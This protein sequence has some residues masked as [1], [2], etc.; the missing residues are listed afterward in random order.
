MESSFAADFRALLDKHGI[1]GPRFA[2]GMGA[3]DPEKPKALYS[4]P[5]YD[6]DELVAGTTALVEGKWSV[7]GEYVHRFEGVFS[8]YLNQVESVMVNSGSS[9]D[10]LMVAAAKKRFGWQDGDGVIVSPVGFPTTISAI[11]LNGLTPVFVDIEWN[12]LNADNGQIERILDQNAREW[13]TASSA[14]RPTNPIIVSIIVSPVLG[15]PPNINQL[16]S[17]AE[18][19]GVRLLLDGCDSLGSKWGGKH[20]AEYVTATTT[21]FFPSHHIST[22]QGGMISSNDTELIRI[23]R[24]MATWGRACYCTGAANLLPNGVC[25]CRFKTW[26]AS[27]PEVVVDHKYVFETAIA[28][29]LQ[30]LDLQGALGLAQMDKLEGIHYK[31]RQAASRLRLMIEQ[32]LNRFTAGPVRTISEVA[33]HVETSWFGCPIVCSTLAYKIALVAHLE[34]AGIQT[35]NYFAGN[36]LLHPGYAHLGRADRYPNANQVLEKVF[37]LGTNPGWTEEHFAH[38]EKTLQSF[39]APV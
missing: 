15:N 33:P 14:K 30:P 24:Q 20:L 39:T 22:L 9:A 35:R 21:S 26:L 7:A 11:T 18:K 32:H 38:I 10:L 36:I 31:R 16:T 5:I 28:Y 4:G 13:A 27:C 17:L 12:T 37:F 25:G 34:K 1:K 8:K 19:Y 29:N 23:A 6:Q 2:H 3:F